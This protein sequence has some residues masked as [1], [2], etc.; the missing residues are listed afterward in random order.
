MGHGSIVFRGVPLTVQRG[1]LIPEGFPFAASLA[2]LFCL[3]LARGQATYWLA[4]V[5]TEQALRRV[6]PARGW[7]ARLHRWLSGDATDRGRAILNR[8]GLAAVPLCYLTVG[9]QTIVLATAGVI[10]IPWGRFTLAQIPGAAAWAAIYSTIGFAVWAAA[11]QA[12]VLHHW[13]LAVVLSVAVAMALA[14]IVILRR[15]RAK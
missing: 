14:G 3:A 15:R 4:R 9:I 8:W 13:W 10:R 5:V 2:F 6:Q 7:R 11:W 1:A 12:A